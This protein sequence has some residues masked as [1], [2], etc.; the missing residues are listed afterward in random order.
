MSTSEL[1]SAA[2]QVQAA[3]AA[4]PLPQVR[5]LSVEIV[6]EGV[7]ISGRVESFY[8]K[9]RAQ[10]TLRGIVRNGQLINEVVVDTRVEESPQT[11]EQPF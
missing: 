10:E 2:Q 8:L 1:N 7:L 4:C 9:Q 11:G 6:G 3:L 5:R